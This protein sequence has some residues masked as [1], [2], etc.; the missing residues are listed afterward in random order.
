MV[1]SVL[2][3][4]RWYQCADSTFCLPAVPFLLP[5]MSPPLVLVSPVTRPSPSLPL[6]PVCFRPPRFP[7]QMMPDNCQGHGHGHGAS[8]R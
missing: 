5:A 4:E 7:E 1:L 3:I 6:V 2:F 8:I